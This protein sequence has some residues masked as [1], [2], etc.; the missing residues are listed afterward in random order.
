[1]C[2]LCV[3]YVFQ[4]GANHPLE[5]HNIIHIMCFSSTLCVF[6]AGVGFGHCSNTVILAQIT[7]GMKESFR[8]VVVTPFKAAENGIEA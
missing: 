3:L 6:L 4:H 2:F 8:K 5:T 7:R 1:M